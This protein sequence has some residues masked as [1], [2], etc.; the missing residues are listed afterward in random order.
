MNLDELIP[1][2]A[3]AIAAATPIVFACIGETISER[4]GVINLSADGTLLLAG[5]SGFAAAQWSNSIWVGFAAAA[6][7][8]ALIALIVAFGAIT[9]RQSQIAIGFVLALLCTDLSSFLGSPFVLTQGPQVPSFH[10]PILK[11]IPI[12]GAIFFQSNWM[13]YASYLLIFGS[14][15]FFYHTRG[16][17]MLRAIGEQPAAAFAR[18]TNVIAWRYIYTL[19]GGALMGI[20]GAAF[21][22]DVKAGWTH[23]HVAG[24]GWIALAIVIFGGWNPWRA[25]LGAYFFGILQSLSSRAQ[26]WIDIIPTQVFPVLPFVLMIIVLVITSSGWIDRVAAYLPPNARRVLLRNLRARAPAALGKPFEQ[27]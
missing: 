4:A 27:D 7:V 26:D 2:L 3:I 23:R 6:L 17:L 24:Y 11:D 8:G 5:M 13:V 21:T 16:G 12:I 18:G 10:F 19:V 1:L 9:L 20:A 15:F 14:W 22:L 25:A